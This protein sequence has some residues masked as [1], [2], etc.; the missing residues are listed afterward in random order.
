MKKRPKKFAVF[1]NREPRTFSV[2][3]EPSL[4]SPRAKRL[5]ILNR[6]HE[7]GWHENDLD[8]M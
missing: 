5:K 7:E 3:V 4:F 8:S 1:P 2:S 6:I